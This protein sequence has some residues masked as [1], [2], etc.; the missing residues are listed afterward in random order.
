VKR[1]ATELRDGAVNHGKTTV[2][3][4]RW[5]CETWIEAAKSQKTESKHSLFYAASAIQRIAALNW[6]L[7]NF[8]YLDNIYIKWYLSAI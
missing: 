5:M 4:H 7:M 6:D 8:K 2:N 3:L 1:S